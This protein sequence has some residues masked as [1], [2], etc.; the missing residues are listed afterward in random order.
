VQS[1]I[2]FQHGNVWFAK[3]ACIVKFYKD[4][5]IA[6]FAAGGWLVPRLRAIALELPP[7]LDLSEDVAVAVVNVVGP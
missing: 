3:S 5:L 7:V 2:C 6:A 4:C 1:G